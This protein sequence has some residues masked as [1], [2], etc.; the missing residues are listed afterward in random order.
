MLLPISSNGLCIVLP[1][2]EELIAQ[3]E[4]SRDTEL[5]KDNI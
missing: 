5:I 3:R 1:G 4:A 2:G